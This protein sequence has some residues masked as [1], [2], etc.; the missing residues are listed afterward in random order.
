MKIAMIDGSPKRG[1]SNSGYMLQVLEPLIS[2]GNEMFHYTINKMTFCEG[3]CS[4]LCHMDTLI[5]SFP[6]YIDAIPSHLF[7]ELINLEERM[8]A[9]RAVKA[10]EIYVYAMINNGF[11]EGNQCRVALEILR[12]WCLRSG[13]YFGQAICQGAGEMMGSMEK[14][15]LD[16]GPLKNLGSALEN[17]ADHIRSR[18]SE[19]PVFLS[20]E[21]PRF[22]WRHAATHMFWNTSAKRNGLKEKDVLKRLL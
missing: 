11:F 22:A 6:L 20:P 9:E 1:K 3:R 5:F 18:S 8:K 17:L 13:L 7:R 19:E 16:Q 21:F 4:E 2:S 12:N 14:V 15:P 10:E